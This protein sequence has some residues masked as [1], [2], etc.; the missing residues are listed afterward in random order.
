MS[1]NNKD[2]SYYLEFEVSGQRYAIELV[3]IDEVLT[4]PDP[5]IIRNQ[6]FYQ[7]KEQVKIVNLEQMS[8][9]TLQSGLSI[10]VIEGESKKI[11]ILANSVHQ[12][13]TLNP[14]NIST[15]SKKGPTHIVGEVGDGEA[16]TKILCRDKLLKAA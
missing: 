4:S 9:L 11:G 2:Y 13:I 16:K 15:L 5:E 12:L 10:L 7:G 14:Q 1:E 3:A 6:E 8:E